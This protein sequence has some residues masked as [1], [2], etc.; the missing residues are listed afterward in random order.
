MPLGTEVGLGPGDIVLDGNPAPPW[1]EAQQPPHFSANVCCG[2][3]PNGRPSQ[4]LLSYCL[5]YS[6]SHKVRGRHPEGSPFRGSAIPKVRFRV[7]VDVSSVRFREG[8]G[9]VGLG[10][11]GLRLV[12]LG[13][14]LVGLWLG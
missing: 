12:G 4:Q 11:V 10:L 7:R 5:S 1:R 9:L 8:S 6:T 14:E 3:W 13:I 2:L